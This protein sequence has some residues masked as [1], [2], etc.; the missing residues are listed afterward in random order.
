LFSIFVWAE[1]DP[2]PIAA[3][4]LHKTIKL[5]TVKQG[6]MHDSNGSIHSGLLEL[7]RQGFKTEQIS[8]AGILPARKPT[9]IKKIKELELLSSKIRQP[10]CFY[11]ANSQNAIVFHDLLTNLQDDTILLF[12]LPASSIK[13]QVILAQTIAKWKESVIPDFLEESMLFGLNSLS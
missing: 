2:C 8:Y 5:A 12:I 1:C 11:S 4:A 9:R 10:Y 3:L 13:P 6:M 7:I